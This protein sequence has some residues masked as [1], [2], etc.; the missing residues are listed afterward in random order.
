M[1]ELISRFQRRISPSSCPVATRQHRSKKVMDEISDF[2]GAS[3]MLRVFISAA[4][5]NLMELSKLADII[6]GSSWVLKAAIF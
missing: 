6:L 1:E 4:S 5:Q 2:S 3:T